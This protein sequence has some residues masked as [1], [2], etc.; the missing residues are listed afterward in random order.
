V[1]SGI[2]GM[3]DRDKFL[4]RALWVSVAYN[5]AAALLF[6]FPASSFGRLAGLPSPV[7]PVYSALV[8]FF[9]ALFGGTYAWLA[10][11]P[12]TAGSS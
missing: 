4:R 11:Q 12:I 6:A 2:G 5:L 3:L 8:A 1:N 9:V 10:R 7:P